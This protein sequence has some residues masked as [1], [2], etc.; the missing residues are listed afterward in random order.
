M[1]NLPTFN[2]WQV[3]NSD[4]DHSYDLVRLTMDSFLT[5]IKIDAAERDIMSFY[6]T[7]SSSYITHNANLDGRFGRVMLVAANVAS[8]C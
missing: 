5:R 8:S 1:E 4:P 7:Q 3:L 2:S 6:S